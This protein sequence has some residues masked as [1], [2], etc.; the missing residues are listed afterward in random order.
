MQFDIVDSGNEG[1]DIFLA[2]LLTVIMQ[3]WQVHKDLG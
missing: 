1:S 2:L 3:G